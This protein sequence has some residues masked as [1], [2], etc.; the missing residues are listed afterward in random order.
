M[1]TNRFGGDNGQADDIRILVTHAPKSLLDMVGSI[2]DKE[3]RGRPARGKLI[4]G[5]S[6]SRTP[7]GLWEVWLTTVDV[8]PE[9]PE[10]MGE[11]GEVVGLVPFY[12]RTADFDKIGAMEVGYASN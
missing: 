1:V 10:V 9:P 7:D 6:G 8:N 11:N 5:A 2:N 12:T 4:T 3:W